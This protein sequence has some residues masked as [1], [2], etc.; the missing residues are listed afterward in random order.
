MPAAAI[1][2][3]SAWTLLYLR[4]A[5]AG[6]EA[7]LVIQRSTME[8]KRP[9]PGDFDAV[10]RFA[11]EFAWERFRSTLERRGRARL[12]L[13]AHLVHAAQKVASFEGEFVAMRA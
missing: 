11:D 5:A 13:T 1:A 7:Q 4:L 10:C 2:T 9:I 3:L 8:Y 12:T 6:I